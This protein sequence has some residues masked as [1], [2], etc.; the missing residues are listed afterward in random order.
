MSSHYAD[1]KAIPQAEM[2]QSQV[3]AH[4]VQTLH[5][6][7]PRFGGRIG[8]GFPAYGQNRTLDFWLYECSMDEAP[9]AAEVTQWRDILNARGGRFSRLAA[10]CQ[11]WLDEE[12]P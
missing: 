10:L 7:L 1:L 9:S 8:I 3:V 2:L 6:L 12:Q 5:G 11:T 4:I